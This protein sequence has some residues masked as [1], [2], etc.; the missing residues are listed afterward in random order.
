MANLRMLLLHRR[1]LD[2]IPTPL[3]SMMADRSEHAQDQVG[4]VLHH[5]LKP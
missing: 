3:S 2:G 1:S 4:A 5:L